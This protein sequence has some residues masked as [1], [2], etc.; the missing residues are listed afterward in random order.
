MANHVT[1]F[2][3]VYGNDDVLKEVQ[4]IQHDFLE[5]DV[6]EWA[7]QRTDILAII[8]GRR[9][10][11]PPPAEGERWPKW[12]GFEYRAR[13][14]LTFTSASWP[15][16]E[17][18]DHLATRLSKLDDC[19]VT[20]MTWDGWPLECGARI[21]FFGKQTLQSFE[22]VSNAPGVGAGCTDSQES[23]DPLDDEAENDRKWSALERCRAEV[24]SRAAASCAWIDTSR[25]S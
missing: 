11:T 10:N 18:Q 15:V 16:Y 21:N 2:I 7:M 24:I 9:E 22:A 6:P 19:V 13:D 14:F 23:G 17:L 3:S 12:A 5:S 20:L 8:Y 25:F 1:S 4:R